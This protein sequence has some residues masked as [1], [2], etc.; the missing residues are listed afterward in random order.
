MGIWKRLFRGTTAGRLAVRPTMQVGEQIRA[1]NVAE[2]S[3]VRGIGA[4]NAVESVPRG[5]AT[6]VLKLAEF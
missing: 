1:H 4:S 5:F 3:R 6:I 2:T